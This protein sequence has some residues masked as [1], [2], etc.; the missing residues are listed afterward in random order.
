MKSA[1]PLLFALSAGLP[2]SGQLI[3]EV[4]PLAI[5]PAGEDYA[6]VILDSGFV[7][8]SVRDNAAFVG[9]V[10]AESGK[11]L[12]DLYYVPL[13]SGKAGAPV[14]F[15]Q[16]LSTP[17]NEGPASF[18]DAGRTICFT[19][20]QVLPKKLSNMRAANGQLGLFFSHLENEAW[21]MPEPFP[22]NEPKSSNMHP[23][24]SADGRTLVFASD[25][26][27]GYGGMDL[28]RCERTALGW[29]APQN[30][31]PELNTQMDE[32][33][34]RLQADGTLHF[35]S[36]R[37]GG[38]G[39]LDI[40]AAQPKGAGWDAPQSMPTPVNSER[41]EHGY[42]LL[43]DAY[44]AMISSDRS[45]ADAIYHVKRT[46]PKFRDCSEQKRNNYCYTLRKR[47]HAATSSIP[48]DHF[49][50]MGD[51]TRIKGYLAQHCYSKP[52]RYVVR[53][54]L[55][56]RKTGTV[57]HELGEQALEVA[58]MQ[59]AWAAVQD[60]V[61]TGR[62]VELNGALS[63]LPGI[64][65]AEYHWDL[66]D[67]SYAEG[68]RVIHAFK[69]PGTYQIRLDVIGEPEADGTINNRCNS[70]SVV[71]LDRF[72]DHEDLAVVAEYQDAF[73]KTHTFEYQE[74]P[75]DDVSLSG[76]SLTDAVFSVQLFSSKERIDLDDARFTQIKKFYRV[77]ERFDP[78]AGL[79]TYSVGETK[80]A[81]DL[82]QVFKK[83][84]ELQFLDAEVFALREEKLIDLSLLDLAKLEELNHRKLRTN[85][86]HFAYK[87]AAIEDESL[88]VLEQILGLMRQHPELHLVIEAHTDDI[89]GH[90]Y[91][92]ELSQSRALSVMD[93]LVD[94]GVAPARLVPVGHGKNQPIMSNKSEEGRA[95]NRRVEFRMT[96]AGSA[97]DPG[98]A[99]SG[100]SR[101][102]PRKH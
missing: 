37:L 79:Y 56:D 67:G 48:V 53:S 97:H 42:H 83:V 76:E 10:D 1:L 66:G 69:Q 51:G 58:D 92:L 71:V 59:Q 17:V 61:R 73:G 11:P 54:I 28:Y 63:Y 62:R 77:V 32:V 16:N 27:G 24:F 33:Y 40:Y 21:T 47:P 31:G 60:T 65:P 88:E 52:G 43:P 102:A 82:Y 96:V 12:S 6:P 101:R 99:L 70:R 7:M 93:F 35:S 64:R 4:S 13:E 9:F 95:R 22:F 20:N 100:A 39:G 23:A 2:L 46:V 86:I 89:G 94:A 45:G 68:L 85:A 87:S 81:E 91:N 72:K 98:E 90:R 26:P 25:R 34:P 29:S 80:S 8:C 30:L 5:S 49:W 44:Q 14:L 74:L 19:R 75:F 50:D 3:Y 57:F 84:K 41:N 18:T 38:L 55:V 78:V 36:N 15:S